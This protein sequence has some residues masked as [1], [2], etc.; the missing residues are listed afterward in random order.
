[1]GRAGRFRFLGGRLS[2]QQWERSSWRSSRGTFDQSL[3]DTLPIWS[4]RSAVRGWKVLA[5]ALQEVAREDAEVQRRLPQGHMLFVARPR[6]AQHVEELGQVRR[7]FG[8]QD[9]GLGGNAPRGDLQGLHLRAVLGEHAR[10]RLGRCAWADT[11]CP[12]RRTTRGSCVAS[13]SSASTTGARSR[14]SAG[15][16]L[17]A[18]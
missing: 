14:G 1:M 17:R 9:V 3:P 13:S 15:A 5:L 12:S 10:L 7:R 4:L 2:E 11:I 8:G 16:G 18:A 6:R